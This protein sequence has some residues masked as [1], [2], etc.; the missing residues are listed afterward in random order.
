MGD[1]GAVVLGLQRRADMVRLDNRLRRHRQI[2]EPDALCLQCRG[3]AA[4]IGQIDVAYLEELLEIAPFAQ[5]PPVRPF[6]DVAFQEVPLD[7]AGIDPRAL[8]RRIAI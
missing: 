6:V 5:E 3:E 7:L 4:H 1:V 2:D 8:E